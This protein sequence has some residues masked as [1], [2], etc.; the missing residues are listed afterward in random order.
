VHIC[1]HTLWE[2]MAFACK[3][4]ILTHACIHTY[5]HAYKCVVKVQRRQEAANA[6]LHVCGYLALRIVKLL[7]RLCM[8][9]CV[10]VWRV[11]LHVAAY[12]AH[13][14]IQGTLGFLVA[15]SADMHA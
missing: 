6:V 14:C 1:I 12:A 2:T 13:L 4:K 9:V 7:A 15:L 11:R 5:T 3:Q 8:F 10:C